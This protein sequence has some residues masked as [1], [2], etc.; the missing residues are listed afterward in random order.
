MENLSNIPQ[1]PAPLSATLT[2]EQAMKHIFENQ[3]AILKQHHAGVIEGTD[4][5]HVHDFRVAIRRTRSALSQMKAI[6]PEQKQIHFKTH[7]KTLGQSTNRLRDLDVY[8]ENKESYREIL[9]LALQ[10]GL[11]VFFD[12]LKKEWQQ[13]HQKITRHL[14]SK[15]YQTKLRTWANF[16]KQDWSKSNPRAQEPILPIAQNAIYKQFKKVRKHGKSIDHQT[17]DEQRHRLRIECKKLRYILEFFSTLFPPEEM[18]TLIANLKS[19]QG[20]LGTFNDLAMHKH[21]LIQF[22]DQ[23]QLPPIAAAIGGL[24]V[25]MHEKQNQMREDFFPLFKKFNAKRNRQRYRQLFKK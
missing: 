24:I 14:Q 21:D 25:H 10:P 7:F 6:L 1:T 19:L 12:L 2:A 16:L 4:P 9:P 23:T 17:P 18:E 8:L 22:L 11:E 13:E 15:T 20:H 3:M 5:E